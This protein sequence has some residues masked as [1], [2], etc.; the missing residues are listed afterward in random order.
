MTI[1]AVIFDLDGVITDTAVFHYQA[2]RQLAQGL[3]VTFT[4]DDNESLKGIDRMGSLAW[5]LAKGGL[6][7]PH[8]QQLAL[9]E[10]K[11][12][13][14]LRLVATMTAADRLP[15]ITSL[16][17]E[18][19]ALGVKKG[20][21]S[22]SKNA[23]LVLSRLGLAGQFDYV[24]D[25]AKV[26]RSKPDPEVFLTVAEALGCTPS[27]CLGVED[28]VAGVQAI[29][30]AGMKAIGIGSPAVLTQAD[31]VYPSPAQIPIRLLL[32]QG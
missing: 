21:A 20:V 3:G 4:E 5:I 16:L 14:Y 28:A 27:Q 6:S 30:A 15:G 31:W 32:A 2:W 8:E 22:A 10:Q 18:L 23:A 25:A 1:H 17:A 29:K 24:A 9:A 26:S 7:L 12:G 11:N 19:D 13:H